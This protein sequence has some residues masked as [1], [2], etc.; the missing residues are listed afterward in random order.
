MTDE[1]LPHPL[2]VRTEE[3]APDPDALAALVAGNGSTPDLDMTR[4]KPWK[5]SALLKEDLSNQWLASG[6]LVAD[7]YGQDAGELK[8]L[9]SYFGLARLVG[10]TGGVPILG[11]WKVPER[12]RAL[13]F[14]AEGGRKP[15]TRRL[16]RMCAAHGLDPADLEDW[17]I[18]IFDHAPLD[19]T[20]FRGLLCHRLAEYKPGFVHLD[21]LYPFQPMTVSSSQLNQVGAMLTEV[22][23]IVAEHDAIMWITAHMNQTGAGFDLKRITGAGVGEWGDSWVLMKHRETPDVDRG[24][25]AIELSIGSRQCGGR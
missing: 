21:P 16:N 6:L 17:L 3:Y 25:F 14:I 1:I 13:A 19:S 2:E 20:L 23:Q 11:Q 9:K 8:T 10:L 24:R 4:M 7:T 22:Q 18:P 12:Q 15:W 5:I